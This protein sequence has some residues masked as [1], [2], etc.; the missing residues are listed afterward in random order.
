MLGYYLQRVRID[1]KRSEDVVTG[2]PA[3]EEE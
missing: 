1:I 3:C 2:L